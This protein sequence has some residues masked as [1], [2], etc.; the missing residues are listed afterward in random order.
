MRRFLY[1][2]LIV[3]TILANGFIA[4]Q[5]LS[6]PVFD[7]GSF[8]GETSYG[9]SGV[10]ALAIGI[11]A[12]ETQLESSDISYSDES[13]AIDIEDKQLTFTRFIEALLRIFSIN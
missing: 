9:G 3:F 1:H 12:V 5:A 2:K 10:S 8:R 4:Q 11:G 7:T 6:E 13:Y